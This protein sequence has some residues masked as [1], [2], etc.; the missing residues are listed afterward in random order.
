MHCDMGFMIALLASCVIGPAHGSEFGIPNSSAYASR[1]WYT[2]PAQYWNNSLPI[3]NGRLGGTVWG[4]ITSEKV[5][6]NEDTLWTGPEMNRLNPNA[7][8]T[9]NTVKGWLL[10]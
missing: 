7:N 4:A 9:Y 10:E 3:G 2:S 8:P 5:S 1:L 6:L